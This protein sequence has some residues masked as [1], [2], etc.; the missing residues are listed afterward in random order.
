[1]VAVRRFVVFLLLV[2][3]FTTSAWAQKPSPPQG[4]AVVGVGSAREEAHVL[5]RAV[6]ASSLRP[7]TLDEMRARIAAGDPVPQLVSKEAKEL[8]E[9]R[10]KVTGDDAASRQLLSGMAKQLNVQALLVLSVQTAEVDG[11]TQTTESARL[12]LAESGDFDAARYEP[13]AGVEGPDGWKSTVRSLEGR[14]PPPPPAPAPNPAT[15]PVPPTVSPNEAPPSKPFYTS[16]WFWGAIG[17]AILVGGA[18]YIASRDT[19]DDPIHLQMRV[20]R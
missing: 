10:A 3:T 19:S 13:E 7:R 11:G 2:L 1:M 5:A 17:A 15:Q 4:V 9:L 8:G 18:F 16:A 12:F 20:P 14:F 6:Y